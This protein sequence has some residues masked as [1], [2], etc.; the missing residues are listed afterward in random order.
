VEIKLFLVPD[1][2]G[3]DRT[4]NPNRHLTP[5]QMGATQGL[6]VD[7]APLLTAPHRVVEIILEGF[8]SLVAIG[9]GAHSLR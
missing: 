5:E 8:C 9:D 4:M 3:E 2:V 7:H 6:A 1:R